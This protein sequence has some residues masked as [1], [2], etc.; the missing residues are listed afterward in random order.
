[1]IKTMAMIMMMMLMMLMIRLV[2]LSAQ[3]LD[4]KD[5]ANRVKVES[6]SNIQCFHRLIMRRIMSRKF[7]NFAKLGQLK[8]TSF[9]ISYFAQVERH[10]PSQIA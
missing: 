5:A 7:R 8:L 2:C 1:M 9:P 3:L 10:R 4:V 6:W